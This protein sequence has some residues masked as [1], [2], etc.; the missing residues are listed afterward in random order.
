MIKRR[1]SL[2]VITEKSPIM[3]RWDGRNFRNERGENVSGRLRSSFPWTPGDIGHFQYENGW[4]RLEEYYADCYFTES[5]MRDL[6]RER[7]G[8][9]V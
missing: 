6:V 5:E 8:R 9:E 7:F 2:E 1:S 3:Y 4:T